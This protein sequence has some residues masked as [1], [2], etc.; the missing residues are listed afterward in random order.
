MVVRA[1]RL[2]LTDG[3]PALEFY[4]IV[5]QSDRALPSRIMARKIALWQ[6]TE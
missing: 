1:C 6:L 2:L 5:H 4:L 3:R